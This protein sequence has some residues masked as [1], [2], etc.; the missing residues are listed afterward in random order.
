LAWNKV[1]SPQ[2]WKSP[3]CIFCYPR[4][5]TWNFFYLLPPLCPLGSMPYSLCQGHGKWW[6]RSHLCKLH[7]HLIGM[8]WDSAPSLCDS[9][10][11]NCSHLCDHLSFMYLFIFIPQI[12]LGC[13]E[14]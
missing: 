13:L 3:K 2:E 4:S 11:H 7:I 8:L 14:I 1:Y 6:G 5:H 9:D 10:A 12:F